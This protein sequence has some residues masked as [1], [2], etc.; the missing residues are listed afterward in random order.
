MNDYSKY[1][2]GPEI[3][4]KW[5]I[6]KKKYIC[7]YIGRETSQEANQDCSGTRNDMKKELRLNKH[8]ESENVKPFGK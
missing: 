5:N 7:I 6:T 4:Q 3:L 8:I 1:N 2:W